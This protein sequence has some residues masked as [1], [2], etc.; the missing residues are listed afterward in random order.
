MKLSAF[1][2]AFAVAGALILASGVAVTLELWQ[3]RR[4]A[5]AEGLRNA[6]GVAS[7]IGEETESTVQ[8]IDLVLDE[9]VAAAGSAPLRGEDAGRENRALYDYI[10]DRL[11]HLPQADVITIADESGLALFTTRGWPTPEIHLADRDY[12]KYLSVTP[13]DRM[14]I[15]EPVQNKVTRAWTMY[16]TKR[17][18][19]PDGRFRGLALIGVKPEA[20][21]KLFAPVESLRG[22]N[23][24]LV[25]RDGTMLFR[26]PETPMATGGRIPQE[27]PWH[28]LVR[29]GGGDYRS[30]GYFDGEPRWVAVNPLK[31]YPLVVDVGTTETQ[32]LSLWRSRVFA[33]VPVAF[34]VEAS[35]SAL[36]ILLF[37]QFRRQQRDKAELARKSEEAALANARFE[38]TLSSMSQGV[39]MFD[40]EGR[41]LI[42]NRK[43]R[44]LWNAGPDELQPGARLSDIA[45]A[46]AARGLFA[47]E[48][49]HLATSHSLFAL[50]VQP[51]A[52]L[53]LT[54]GRSLRVT[55]DPM[56]GGGWV[57]TH[58]D[59]TD[60]QRAQAEIAHMAMH[61]GLTGLLNRAGFMTRLL[62]FDPPLKNAQIVVLL[63]DFAPLKEI[64][65]TYGRWVGD[66]LLCAAGERLRGVAAT[67]DVVARLGGDEFAI[68]RAVAPDGLADVPAFALKIQAQIGAPYRVDGQEM[69]L[70]AAIG[71]AISGADDENCER[72]V[73]HADL[74]LQ[75]A[76]LDGR[77]GV[78]VFETAMEE[79][80][81]S[82][83]DMARD[84][85]EAIRHRALQVHYQP[86]VDARTLEI[87]AV[88]A[89]ARW[90]D[91]KRGMVP[92]L[93]FI[94]LAEE[95]GMMDEIGEWILRRA[96][97]E[98]ANWPAHIKVAV[99]VSA[100]QVNQPGFPA[101]VAEILALAGLSPD[102]LELEITEA[103]RLSDADHAPAVLG[104]LKRSG[105]S[106]VLDDFG[107]GF[108]SLSYLRRFPFDEIKID[109]SF[110]EAVSM[111]R[112]CARIVTSLAS[113]ALGFEMDCTAEGVETREHFELMRAACVA[114]VQGRYFGE[115]APAAHWDFSRPLSVA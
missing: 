77:Q 78:R 35:L 24:V 57:T 2:I 111:R 85:R 1:K 94:R 81:L 44:E 87:R 67:D 68:L 90:P 101:R 113:L 60:S 42:F 96:C 92:P 115:P 34:V 108:S 40:A 38:A 106:I 52:V 45:A 80:F 58:E 82:R 21:V 66:C 47:P 17:L 16:F 18:S 14:F 39:A 75:R 5:I 98:A 43:Y 25:R 12:F 31:R 79:D 59:I 61:D 99:N 29:M 7:I 28:D 36:L 19:S 54:D 93:K 83:Q 10:S 109:R 86:I 91:P 107:A 63:I 105:V 70:G 112:G 26:D 13:G 71:I 41:L 50:S 20:F 72:I 30:P 32:V 37:N 95:T 27:S 110:I 56:P 8:A 46:R 104:A 114:R 97:L 103:T 55:T 53:K 84:L 89:L 51:P 49:L 64:N 62:E 9:I 33:V 76:K 73:R 22:D 88:E 102:R 65:E 6:E 4:D 11:A 69:K 48:S 74:A 23:V 100:L 15:S 3:L